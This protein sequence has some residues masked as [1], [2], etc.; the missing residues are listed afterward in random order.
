MET[1]ANPRWPHLLAILLRQRRMIISVTLL[2]TVVCAVVLFFR[3]PVYEADAHLAVVPERAR[4]IVS[5]DPKTGTLSE[6]VTEQDLNSEVALLKSDQLLRDVLNAESDHTH[7]AAANSQLALAA[8]RVLTF[9]GRL[10]R[11]VHGLPPVEPLEYEIRQVRSRLDIQAVKG[12]NLIRISYRDADPAHAAALVNALAKRHVQRPAITSQDDARQFFESQRE[13]LYDSRRKAEQALQEFYQ[14][15]NI[16]SPPESAEALRT[17]LQT[18]QTTA[19]AART[20]F[21]E[22][23][24]RARHMREELARQPKANNFN[25]PTLGGNQSDPL[26][27]LRTRIVELE[28]QRSNLLA[29]FAPTSSKIAEIDRQLSEA[30]AIQRREEKRVAGLVSQP[31]ETMLL[32]LAKTDADAAALKARV[33]AIEEQIQRDQP[34][35]AHLESVASERERLEQE[36]GAAREAL[37]T[38]RRKQEEAR[39]SSALDRSQIVNVSIVEAAR[40]PTAPLPSTQM[41][42]IIIGSIF[43]LLIGIGV[44]LLRDRLDPSIKSAADVHD[45]GGIPVL[46]DMTS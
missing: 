33:A 30:H 44:A 24:A 7:A 31:R 34:R 25:L 37:Q 15:E 32:T 1:A 16:G 18:L 11:S 9:P 10:Y 21:A 42:A 46:A 6:T 26:Q 14:R 12:S 41:T 8:R 4:V 43:S 39:F 3:A 45:L 2:G 35:L 28:L 19:V 29:Q 36:V 20:S 5:P 13:V 17:Q 40:V 27:F 22:A 38:Y 23:E